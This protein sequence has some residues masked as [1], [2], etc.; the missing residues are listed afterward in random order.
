M[1]Q[2]YTITVDGHQPE[3]RERRRMAAALST[4]RRF[5]VE[6]PEARQIEIFDGLPVGQKRLELFAGQ[7]ALNGA[8]R[9]LTI[10]EG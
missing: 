8:A 4:A 1:T 10:L 2:T 3:P 9:Y 6:Y 7:A 5:V